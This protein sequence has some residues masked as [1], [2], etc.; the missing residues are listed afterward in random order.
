M[1][2][3]VIYQTST[4]SIPVDIRERARNLQI[5]ISGTLVEALKNKI[6]EREGEASTNPLHAVIPTIPSRRNKTQCH[7]SPLL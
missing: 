5:P 1:R 6:A 4:V 2:N 7:L 3:G